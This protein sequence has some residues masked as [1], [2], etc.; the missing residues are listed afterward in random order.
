MR[1]VSFIS[2]KLTHRLNEENV[3]SDVT[4]LPHSEKTLPTSNSVL[5]QQPHS[6]YCSVLNDWATAASP[7]ILR[8]GQHCYPPT[9][10][11]HQRM[12]L[13]VGGMSL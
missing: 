9:H 13:M 5:P 3:F 11:N 8:I 7:C 12:K 4:E 10:I 2:L 6:I 1:K